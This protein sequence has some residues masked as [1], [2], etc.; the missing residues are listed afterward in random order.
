MAGFNLM[1]SFLIPQL[2][3]NKPVK[4]AKCLSTSSCLSG[5]DWVG[6]HPLFKHRQVVDGVFWIRERY[7][8]TSWNAANIF[9]IKGRDRDLL[10]DTG[11]GIFSLP[12]F[13]K[14]SGLREDEVKPL[15]VVCTHLHFD[16]TGGAH[17]FE[18]VDIHQIEAGFL[19]NGNNFMMASWVT[20][21][22]V[23]PKPS[24]EWNASNYSVK[25][26]Q[27]VVGIEDGHVYD[28][29]DRQ[30]KVI[31]LPGHSPGSISVHDEQNG[32]IATSDTLYQTDG[33]LIDWYPGSNATHMLQSVNRLLELNLGGSVS[34]V[35]PG[36]NDVL[37]KVEAEEAA[38]MYIEAHGT[39]RI[40]K[41]AFSRARATVVS[42]AHS[43]LSMP[44]FTREW[45]NS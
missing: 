2:K 44:E 26:P 41:K 19:R 13:L 38:R 29:G 28:L 42:K 24:S 34:C 17:Q 25:P 45:M 32:V 27:L 16:H 23:S 22:E 36:H 20:P 1:R 39:P 37:D 40:I 21:K 8:E 14:S 4:S 9:F 5:S 31:H 30:F 18:A 10:I 11:V 35:L 43:V 3:P 33:E 6:S 7:F 15:S 12:Q